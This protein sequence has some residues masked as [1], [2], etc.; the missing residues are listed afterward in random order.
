[1]RIWHM[2]EAPFSFDTAQ[3]LLADVAWTQNEGYFWQ[4]DIYHLVNR[5]ALVISWINNLS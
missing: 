2:I 1:M 4:I 3:N 5:Y